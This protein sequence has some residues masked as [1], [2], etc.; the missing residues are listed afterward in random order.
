[1]TP[2]FN[3]GAV[4]TGAGRATISGV[5]AAANAGKISRPSSVASNAARLIVTMNAH[6]EAV[7]TPRVGAADPEMEASQCQLFAGLRQVTNRGG[8]EAAD[9]VVFV[10]AEI[11]AELLVEIGDR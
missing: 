4:D 5:G 10:V 11:G 3:G 1:M 8:D 7:H 9:G 6:D 2:T